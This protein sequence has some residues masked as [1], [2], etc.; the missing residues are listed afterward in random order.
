MNMTQFSAQT[1]L[2]EKNKNYLSYYVINVLKDVWSALVNGVEL[3]FNVNK[4]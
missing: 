2:G 1:L 3:G 4:L